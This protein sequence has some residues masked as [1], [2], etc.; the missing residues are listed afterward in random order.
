MSATGSKPLDLGDKS[1]PVDIARYM[2]KVLDSIE[3]SDSWVKVLFFSSAKT[4][5]Y[6]DR[7]VG[8]SR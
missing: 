4:D 6:W 7:I 3:K 2:L 5:S 8:E 1:M